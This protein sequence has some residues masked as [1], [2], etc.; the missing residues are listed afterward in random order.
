MWLVEVVNANETTI[1][2]KKF[3]FE[4]V[5]VHAKVDHSEFITVQCKRSS[6]EQ[7]I[8]EI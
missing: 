5:R 3:C 8:T 2:L 4:D 7:I 6:A 1:R